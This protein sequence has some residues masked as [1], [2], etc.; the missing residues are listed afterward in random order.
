MIIKAAHCAFGCYIN[1]PAVHG[2]SYN[3]GSIEERKT[4]MDMNTPL[5]TSADR[6]RIIQRPKLNGSAAFRDNNK[7]PAVRV[8][9]RA[10]QVKCIHSKPDV[11]IPSACGKG[12]AGYACYGIRVYIKSYSRRPANRYIIGKSNDSFRQIGCRRRNGKVI[13]AAAYA[14]G[15][16]NISAGGCYGNIAVKG[17]GVVKCYVAGG[18]SCNVY[19]PFQGCPA[20]RVGG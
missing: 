10:V 18:C 5:D 11:R 6:G 20:E 4:W 9:Y 2:A 15:E 7:L 12:S 17:Y 14:G 13:A 8:Y 16:C 3:N 1:C 19:I